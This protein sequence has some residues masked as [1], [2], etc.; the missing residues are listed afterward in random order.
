M[1]FILTILLSCVLSGPHV[2]AQ[3]TKSGFI[4]TSDG[5]RIHYVEAGEGKAIVFIPGWMMPGY[6][7][8]DFPAN[9]LHIGREPFE[10]EVV[11][12]DS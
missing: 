10:K 1:R 5:V 8:P 7:D 2:I 3:A 12:L 6:P 9:K 11:F 4:K